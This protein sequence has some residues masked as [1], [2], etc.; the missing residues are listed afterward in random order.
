MLAFFT[1][2]IM[3][4][5]GYAYLREGMFTAFSMCCNVFVAGL[6][7]FNFFEPLATSMEPTV[8]GTPLQGYEDFIFLL[9][10]FSLTL[11]VLRVVTNVLSPT[12]VRFPTVLQQSGGAIFG[13]LTGYLVSGFLICALQTLPWSQ[14]FMGFD[15]KLDPNSSFRRVLPPDRVWLALM[16]RAGGYAFCNDEDSKTTG[17]PQL[18]DTYI[19]KAATFDKYG[20]FEQRYARY[21]R[22][23]DSGESMKYTGEFDDLR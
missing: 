10:I 19:A 8:T 18:G 21:R 15:P 11:G 1:L 14:N 22:Y 13:I 2:M 4:L 16:R 3:L 6:V 23:R 7:A 17:K 20:T 12:Q 5:I 9:L